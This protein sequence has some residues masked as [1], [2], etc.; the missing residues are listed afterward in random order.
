MEYIVNQYLLWQ[1]INMILRDM[2]VFSPNM[3]QVTVL[4]KSTNLSNF[5]RKQALGLVFPPCNGTF[6]GLLGH[7]MGIFL[8]GKHA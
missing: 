8:K 4:T 3:P 6:Q 1:I 5:T 7:I 2:L